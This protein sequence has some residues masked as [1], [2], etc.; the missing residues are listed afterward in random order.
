VAVPAAAPTGAALTAATT[1]G[2]ALLATAD[3]ARTSGHLGDAAQALETFVATYPRERR[4][5]AA[6]FT[7]GR[8]Q[9]ARGRLAAAASAFE[10]CSQSMPAGRAHVRIRA[11]RPATSP[12]QR[13]RYRTPTIV[14]SQAPQACYAFA[15]AAGAGVLREW[16]AV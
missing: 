5:P 3:A 11:L 9:S 7:L 4:V 8:V 15:A 13:R 16:E 6:P 12:A 1:A 2:S 14:P 10:R